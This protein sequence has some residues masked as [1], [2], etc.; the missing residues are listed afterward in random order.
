VLNQ[1]IA[2]ANKEQSTGLEQLNQAFNSLDQNVQVNA[3]S[4]EEMAASS[5]EL[6]QQVSALD[7]VVKKL[8]GIVTGRSA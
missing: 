7:D 6:N 4:S 3:S 5:E 1:E 8:D 2:Q